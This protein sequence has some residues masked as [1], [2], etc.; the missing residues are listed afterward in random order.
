[1]LICK[2]LNTSDAF[3]QD[4]NIEDVVCDIA[5]ISVS[6]RKLQLSTLWG[7]VMTSVGET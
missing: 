4:I 7:D 6:G 3:I 1:M 2:A 5:A